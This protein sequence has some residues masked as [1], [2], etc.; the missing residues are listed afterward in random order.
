MKSLV[1]TVK[2]LSVISKINGNSISFLDHSYTDPGCQKLIESMN[3]VT[4]KELGILGPEDP[5]HF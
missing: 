5:Y 4:L 3:A 1:Q 2:R